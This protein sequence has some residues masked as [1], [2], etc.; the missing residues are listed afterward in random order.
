MR[1]MKILRLIYRENMADFNK[2]FFYN[3]LQSIIISRQHAFDHISVSHL[4]HIANHKL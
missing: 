4:P 1:F 3:T 2:S